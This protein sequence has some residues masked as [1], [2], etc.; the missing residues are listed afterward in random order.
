VERKTEIFFLLIIFF[1]AGY[2]RLHQ[3]RS[4]PPG[5]F[6]DEAVEGTKALEIT[7]ATPFWSAFKPF[8]PEDGGREG[9]YV[10]VLA[11]FIK[12]SGGIH[13]PWIVR[14]PAAICGILTVIGIYFLAAEL[15]GPEIGLLSAFLLATNFW[16]V[17]LSRIAFRAIMAPLFLVWALYLLMKGFNVL[18]RN[19]PGSHSSVISLHLAGGILFG[20]GMYTYIAYRVSPAIVLL[21]LLYYWRL[22]EAEGWTRKFFESAAIFVI[23][24][25]IVSLPLA[26]YFY[27]HPGTFTRRMSD[28]VRSIPGNIIWDFARTSVRTLAMFNGAGDPDWRDNISGASELYWPVGVMFV[29]GVFLGWCLLQDAKLT[30][31]DGRENP[32]RMRKVYFK[33]MSPECFPIVLLF[34]WFLIGMLPASCSLVEFPQTLRSVLMLPPAIILSAFGGYRMYLLLLGRFGSV[35]LRLFATVLFTLLTVNVYKDYFKIWANNP[36]ELASFSHNAVLL[37][38]ELNALPRETLKYVV[39]QPHGEL[40]FVDGLPISAQGVMFVTD[41]VRPQE[42]MT[43]NVHYVL[44]DDESKIPAGAMKFYLRDGF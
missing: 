11:V 13:D 31:R 8:Y 32:G 39:V 43:K 14:L 7:H 17:N 37:G 3:I 15:F 40:T 2:L 29:F 44:P 6:I 41:T 18:S 22:A 33:W 26:Y 9:M 20:M 23:S 30:G 24:S 1:I 27:A 25:M 38:H 19:S 21:I 10:N 16:H 12:L 36:A 35:K 4:I 34:A 28:T 5:L 42:Q